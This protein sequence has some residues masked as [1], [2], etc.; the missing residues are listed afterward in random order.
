MNGQCLLKVTARVFPAPEI[1]A[2]SPQLCDKRH[3]RLVSGL[4]GAEV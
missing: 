3:P 1:S 2:I 4:S